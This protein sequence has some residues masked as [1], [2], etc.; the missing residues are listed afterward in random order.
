[1][2]SLPL[3]QRQPQ[4]QL[5]RIPTPL[6]QYRERAVFSDSFRS[7]NTSRSRLLEN[8][9]G[10]KTETSHTQHAIAAVERRA[11]AAIAA[12]EKRN[13]KRR[14][15]KH[16]PL[17]PTG[18]LLSCQ[19]QLASCHA[20]QRVRPH[21]QRNA[22]NAR[23]VQVPTSEQ[24]STRARSCLA[25]SIVVLEE[26]RPRTAMESLPA[27][28]VPGMVDE[29]RPLT[30]SG[31]TRR[32]SGDPGKCLL[33]SRTASW[34][35][36]QDASLRTGDQHESHLSCWP[37][38]TDGLPSSL[39]RSSR[40]SLPQALKSVDDET[41]VPEDIFNSL[42]KAASKASGRGQ[43]Q[44]IKKGGAQKLVR[45]DLLRQSQFR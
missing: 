3:C 28:M 18:P 14:A 8:G 20:A 38:A 41:E 6:E 11:E 31:N 15:R 44:L 2:L 21:M 17:V 34:E 13:E 35:K 24:L 29:Y 9:H 42:M 16:Q 19:K 36:E 32:L 5:P 40:H 33:L 1:M 30:A 7:K 39:S 43:H 37:R 22:S 10:V 25:E 12:V 27:V 26:P 23:S 45:S 4:A